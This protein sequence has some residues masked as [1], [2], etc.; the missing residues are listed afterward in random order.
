MHFPRKLSLPACGMF[1][2]GRSKQP[3]T[4]AGENPDTLYTPL[5]LNP[6]SPRSRRRID[7]CVNPR[8]NQR[9]IAPPI[10]DGY[11]AMADEISADRVFHGFG[12][13]LE[14][15][16]ELKWISGHFPALEGTEDVR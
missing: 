16:I 12:M 1:S 3:W 11:T 5:E 15:T 10:L 14:L 8:K 9:R 4:K 2:C 13:E 6:H 7:C